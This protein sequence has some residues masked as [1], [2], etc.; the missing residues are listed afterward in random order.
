MAASAPRQCVQRS[1][2]FHVD[3]ENLDLIVARH[4]HFPSSLRYDDAKTDATYYEDPSYVPFTPIDLAKFDA[5]RPGGVRY[6]Q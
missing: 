6:N 5:N 4:N 1:V 2:H 3:T